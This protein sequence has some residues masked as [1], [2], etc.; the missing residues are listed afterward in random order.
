MCVE[1]L[2]PRLML[3]LRPSAYCK[4]LEELLVRNE[5]THELTADQFREIAACARRTGNLLVQWT[6]SKYGLWGCD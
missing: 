4:Y 6:L 2:G 5:K 3:R 1:D